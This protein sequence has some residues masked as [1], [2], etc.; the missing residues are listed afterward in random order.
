MKPRVEKPHP[1]MLEN[2]DAKALRLVL[3]IEDLAE[4]SKLT[5]LETF[6]RITTRDQWVKL[7][8]IADPKVL[9][10]EKKA[11]PPSPECELR[12]LQLLRERAEIGGVA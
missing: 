8:F 11:E 6:G 2:R 7:L 5:A 3:A 9:R 10:E 4:Q 12:I 1:R